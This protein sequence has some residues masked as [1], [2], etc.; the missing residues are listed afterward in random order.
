MSELAFNVNGEPFE[1]PAAAAG[2]RVRRLKAKGAPLDGL[3]ATKL[4][5]KSGVNANVGIA[6]WAAHPNAAQVLV[7][8]L[9]SEE[10]QAAVATTGYVTVN[11]KVDNPN[12]GVSAMAPTLKE[13]GDPA[14][15][16]EYRTNWTALFRK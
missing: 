1:V 10:G 12:G 11:P 2:W 16:K 5:V 9:F 8:F 14:F 7:D 6:S 3:N 15:L 4:D 13:M